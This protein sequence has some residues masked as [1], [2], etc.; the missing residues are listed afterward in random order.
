MTLNPLQ[1]SFLNIFKTQ[2]SFALQAFTKNAIFDSTKNKLL[3]VA[4]FRRQKL[5]FSSKR[6]STTIWGKHPNHHYIY[7]K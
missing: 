6:L 1:G 5:A 7:S 2:S 3:L 4:F